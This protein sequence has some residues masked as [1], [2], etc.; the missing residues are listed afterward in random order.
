M[1][2]NDSMFATPTFTPTTLTFTSA[3]AQTSSFVVLA[4]QAAAAQLVKPDLHQHPSGKVP[5]YAAGSGATLACVLLIT[6]PR[7]RRWGALLVVV[8][9]VAALTAVGC[10]AGNTSNTGG[11]GGGGGGTTTPAA[12]GTYTFTITAVSGT[13]VHSTQV[14]VT[15]P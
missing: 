5:W 6:L 7:R 12:A 8:F 14:T 9:S 13:L 15:V 10:G 11:G 1:T 2:N 4:S 3:T